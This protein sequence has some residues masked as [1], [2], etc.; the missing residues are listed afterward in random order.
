MNEELTIQDLQQQ[1]DYFLS[2]PVK[3]PQNPKPMIDFI[4]GMIEDKRDEKLKQLGI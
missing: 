1:L 3:G 4:I 2:R